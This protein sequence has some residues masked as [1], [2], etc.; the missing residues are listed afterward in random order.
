MITEA[1]LCQA[2]PDPVALGDLTAAR[3]SGSLLRAAD[4]DRDAAADSRSTACHRRALPGAGAIGGVGTSQSNG[5]RRV[6][7]S[8]RSGQRKSNRR[9]GC[10]PALSNLQ[11]L[12]PSNWELG[13]TI[14]LPT[15]VDILRITE[16]YREAREHGLLVAFDEFQGN[17]GQ[18]MHFSSL[19]PD[20]LVL[21]AS[22]TKDLTSARAAT[23]P[24]GVAAGGLRRIDDQTRAP[25]Q[26]PRHGVSVCQEIGF[27]LMLLSSTS[28]Q[29]RDRSPS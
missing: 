10:F 7:C 2:D 5:P 9:I 17:G 21:A 18:I 1:T 13:L 27:D 19:L 25:V 24:L 20:Y 28:R 8:S 23:A 14:S 4:H 6:A 3:R 11:G 15:D 12:L 16:V 22:M 26:R 29:G